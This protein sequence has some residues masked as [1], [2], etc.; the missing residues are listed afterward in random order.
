MRQFFW[1]GGWSESFGGRN[2]SNMNNLKM[3]LKPS[4]LDN[5]EMC[6]CCG[7]FILSSRATVV[8]ANCGVGKFIEAIPRNESQGCLPCGNWVKKLASFVCRKTTCGWCSLFEPGGEFHKDV[9]GR[10]GFKHP[11]I[12]ELPD[13]HA[14]KFRPRYPTAPAAAR[15]G[16]RAVP[17]ESPAQGEQHA[18]F[19]NKGEDSPVV[20]VLHDVLSTADHRQCLENLGKLRL[21]DGECARPPDRAEAVQGRNR[22]SSTKTWIGAIGHR[23]ATGERRHWGAELVLCR[24]EWVKQCPALEIIDKICL[25]ILGPEHHRRDDTPLAETPGAHGEEFSYS[26]TR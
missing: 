25:R 12:Q 15:R 23:K 3:Y 20:L 21:L 18:F 26:S 9:A 13:G 24:R 6:N 4:N 14:Q 16:R 22:C 17:E 5:H 10:P 1:S 2:N 7:V 11:V 19:R 8:C